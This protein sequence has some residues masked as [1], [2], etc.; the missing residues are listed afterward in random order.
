MPLDMD[1]RQRIRPWRK[2]RQASKDDIPGQTER[3]PVREVDQ[4]PWVN[5]VNLNG[6]T[7]RSDVSSHWQ[8]IFQDLEKIFTPGR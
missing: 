8:A 1:S 6:K 2:S 5:D 7:V 4:V 3:Q